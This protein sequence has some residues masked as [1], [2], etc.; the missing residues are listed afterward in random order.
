MSERTEIVFPVTG[1]ADGSTRDRAGMMR[2][3][4]LVRAV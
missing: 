4:R 3:T 1:A 2:V